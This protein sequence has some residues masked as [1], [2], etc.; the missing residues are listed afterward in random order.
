MKQKKFHEKSCSSIS[1]A[2]PIIRIRR[3]KRGLFLSLVDILKTFFLFLSIVL[4]DKISYWMCHQLLI[5]LFGDFHKTELHC[6]IV[7][8]TGWAT[9][10]FATYHTPVH[11][12]YICKEIAMVITKLQYECIKNA[13]QYSKCMLSGVF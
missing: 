12:N 5:L 2:A 9:I 3:V 6:P 8:P 4:W 11:L 13:V 1:R 7:C 10:N